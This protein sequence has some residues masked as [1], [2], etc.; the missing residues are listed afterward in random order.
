MLLN[1][2][3]CTHRIAF[4]LL[5]NAS[6]G[7]T[8]FLTGK[9]ILKFFKNPVPKLLFPRFIYTVGFLWGSVAKDTSPP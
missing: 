1:V 4:A 5:R 9:I 3:L 8:H 6:H 2:I 7:E